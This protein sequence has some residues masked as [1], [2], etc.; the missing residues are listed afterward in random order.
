MDLT[1]KGFQLPKKINFVEDSLTDFYGKLVAEPLERGFGAT[2]GNA[3]R[4]VLLSSIE[5]AAVT[6]L[7]IPG[8]LHQF[9]PIKGVK[10]D[11]IDIMLN[12]KKLRFKVHGDDKRTVSI[13]VKGPRVVTGADI[14][15]DSSVE[16]LNDDAHVAT[17]DSGA[18]F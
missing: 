10:E 11:V 15:C 2:L 12:V 8:V 16:V 9:S 17:V 13:K 18:V 14:Q 4:R 6:A 7:R 1:K 3:L 5:G